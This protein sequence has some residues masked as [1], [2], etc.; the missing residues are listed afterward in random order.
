[1]AITISFG[2]SNE[3]TKPVD[4]YPTV[5][6]IIGDANIKQFLGFGNNVEA[7][8]NGVSDQT[9][10]VDGDRVELVTRASTKG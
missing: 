4:Q 9:T 3:V 10:L 2:P 8:V 6:S 5:A 7:R 1:M